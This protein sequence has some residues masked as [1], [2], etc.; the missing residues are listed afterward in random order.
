[1]ATAQIAP[2]V[3]PRPRPVRPRPGR[4]GIGGPIVMYMP[5]GG[6]LSPSGDLG[7]LRQR[8]AEKVGGFKDGPIV[9]ASSKLR[10]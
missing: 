5:E 2:A 7:A 10:K 9:K 8:E 1:M 3:Q 6:K 4:P